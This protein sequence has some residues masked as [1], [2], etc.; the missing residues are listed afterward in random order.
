MK[1]HPRLEKR[2]N[3]YYYIIWS[4]L[5]KE[6]TKTIDLKL[7]TEIMKMKD[8]Q[9]RN[10]G[11]VKLEKIN[12]IRLSEFA[13]EYILARELHDVKQGTI[14]NASLAIRK[15][16]EVCGDLPLRLIKKDE[17]DKFKI[18][19][20]RLKHT[21]TYINILLRTLSSAFTYAKGKG[22]IPENLFIKKD[23][24]APVYLK[25]DKKGPRFLL[26][27]EI[28]ALKNAIDDPEFLSLVEVALNTGLRREEIVRLKMQDI[29]LENGLLRARETKGKKDRLIPIHTDLI[30]PLTARKQDIGLVFPKWQSP[31][32][33]SRLFRH[34]ADK[35]GIPKK[36]G[37]AVHFHDLR[38]TFASYLVLAGVDIFRVKE[39]LG[40]ADIATTMI[41][42]QLK[43]EDMQQDIN[44]LN[45]G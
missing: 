33:I 10:D 32:T 44:K 7:A 12:R 15:L 24:N 41:Y 25:V 13:S 42:A 36:D 19:L 22:Y 1:K 17:I 40:H 3:G 45:F 9:R 16:K 37:V 20:L 29:D 34:Y 39:L 30:A 27:A 6:S 28:A 8:E 35:A 14:D 23:K 31:D 21:R 43:T 11:I 5:D 26:R 2:A 4:R 38:H 18:T